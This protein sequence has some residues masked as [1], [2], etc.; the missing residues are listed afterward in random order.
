M[1]VPTIEALTD[2]EPAFDVLAAAFSTDPGVRRVLGDGIGNLHALYALVVPEMLKNPDAVMLGIRDEQGLASAAVCQ[3]PGKDLSAL[4]MLVRGLPLAWRLGLRRTRVLLRFVQE[5]DEHSP[6]REDQLR[7]AIL[8]TRP[9]AFGR[10]YG[11]ALLRAVDQHAI[12]RGLKAVYL[13][14]D[15]GHYPM[16]LYERFGYHTEKVFDSVAGPVAL[17]VKPVSNET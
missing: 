6:L 14:A 2:L 5:L 17:M 10:G 9:D 13:E 8:G 3:G 16:K 7:L 4:V 12:D 15:N 11:T 1:N